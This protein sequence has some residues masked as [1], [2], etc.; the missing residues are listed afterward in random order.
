MSIQLYEVARCLFNKDMEERY[1]KYENKL[2]RESGLPPRFIDPIGIDLA[3]HS[4]V[5]INSLD[6][7]YVKK[8]K[9]M[10]Y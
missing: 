9:I 4:D 1:E 10:R 3:G 5:Y 6:P 7:L 8:T 2:I